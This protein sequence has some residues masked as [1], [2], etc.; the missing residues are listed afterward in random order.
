VILPVAWGDAAAYCD[1]AHSAQL[2][3][4]IT[5]ILACFGGRERALNLRVVG[6]IPPGSPLNQT[7]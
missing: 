7:T 3:D 6:S 4:E 5:W 1:M 2:S